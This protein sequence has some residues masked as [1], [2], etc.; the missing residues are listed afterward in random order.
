MLPGKSDQAADQSALSSFLILPVRPELLS[1]RLIRQAGS[2]STPYGGSVTISGACCPAGS[3]L[4][5]A[6]SVQ[7]PQPSRWAPMHHTSPVTLTGRSATSGAS[8]SSVRPAVTPGASASA[9]SC[10]VHP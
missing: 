8:F 2:Y 9:S 5:V 4:T 3:A 6:S 1:P 7:S 10:L